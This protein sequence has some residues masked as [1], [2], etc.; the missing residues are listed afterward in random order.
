VT[1]RAAA[2]PPAHLW[3]VPP[4]EIWEAAA[5]VAAERE[6]AHRDAGVGAFRT[7]SFLSEDLLLRGP[8]GEGP[9]RRLWRWDGQ[10]PRASD[11][12][13]LFG[14]GAE[15]LLGPRPERYACY[16]AADVRE[17]A[18]RRGDADLVARWLRLQTFDPATFPRPLTDL[19]GQKFTI[20]DEDQIL[21]HDQTRPFP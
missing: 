13:A 2:E 6:L 19:L 21:H 5:L 8:W 12:P 16:F 3:L 1:L 14:E 9:R 4:G 15:V 18:R 17:L 10:L 11:P 20:F 7:D